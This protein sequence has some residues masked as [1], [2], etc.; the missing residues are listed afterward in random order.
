M[1]T[2]EF[3][4]SE[5]R[6]KKR[7]KIHPYN[8]QKYYLEED[9]KEFIKRIKD[10][11]NFADFSDEVCSK[12]GKRYRNIRNS[13]LEEIDKLAGKELSGESK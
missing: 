11:M 9:V 4:L 2:K 12:E 13:W 6:V 7:S 1:K 3:N 10:V 8:N 5:K